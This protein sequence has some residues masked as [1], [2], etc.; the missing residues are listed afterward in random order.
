MLTVTIRRMR[1]LK[2]GIVS[3]VLVAVAMFIAPAS[4]AHAAGAALRLPV[5]EGFP[6]QTGSFDVLL[7][8]GLDPQR[9][10]SYSVDL[11]LAGLPGVTFTGIAISPAGAGYIFDDLQTPPLSF[12]AFPNAGFIASDTDFRLPG[13]RTL[14]GGE[15]VGLLRIA[16]AIAPDADYGSRPFEFGAGTS[17]SDEQGGEV[18]FS[19]A[20]SEFRVVPEPAAAGLVAIL[21]PL[22][23]RPRRV[24]H[25][26]ASVVDCL[27]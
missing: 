10:A 16:W 23:R 5:V 19:A 8:N 6:G 21:L 9:V 3:I 11:L 24:C 20:P 4:D 17:L 25:R 1:A 18:P 15:T 14:Q 26:P 22:F 13:Y 2:R 7:E 27:P 12:D